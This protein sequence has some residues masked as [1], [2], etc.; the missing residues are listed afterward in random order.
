MK[1]AILLKVEHSK[2]LFKWK[3]HA[4]D[5]EGELDDSEDQQAK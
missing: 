2:E 4:T 5:T 3:L 1:H